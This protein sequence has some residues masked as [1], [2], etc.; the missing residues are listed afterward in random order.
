MKIFKIISLIAVSI[1]LGVFVHATDWELTAHNL[2]D[3]GFR[4]LY[5]LMTTGTAYFLAT[6]GWKYCLGET[7]RNIN[8]GELFMI[9]HLGEML[10]IINPASVIGG[11]AFKVYLLKEKGLQTSKVLSSILVSRIL[12][13]D[14]Q[15]G[16]F[17]ITLVM[18]IFRNTDAVSGL[19]ILK[20]V[21]WSFMVLV[22]VLLAGLG[23][24]IFSSI[25][26]KRLGRRIFR[27]LDQK[28]NIRQVISELRLFFQKDKKAVLLCSFFFM[29]HWIA[30]GMEIYIILKFSGIDTNIP[31]VLFADMGIIIFKA[32]GAFVPGQ[33]GVEE[34]ANKVMLDMIGVPDYGIWI[35]VSVL[36]RCRQLFWIVFGLAAYFLYFKQTKA[37]AGP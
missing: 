13:A 5:L 25:K 22:L 34:F 26:I 33:I 35:T 11:E 28:L 15:L 20:S 36:R 30:G 21:D 32:A 23:Y 24:L 27:L 12:M 2:R 3:F 14:T 10:S 7:A 37:M 1:C 16:L 18:V 6:I 19:N 9:R 17:V 31:A 4:F 8:T 29:L